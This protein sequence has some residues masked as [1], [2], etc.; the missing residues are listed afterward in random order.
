MRKGN[1]AFLACIIDSR[2]S[3][4]KLDQLPVVSEFADVFPEELSGLPPDRE[5]EF[6]ID[7]VPRTSLITISPAELK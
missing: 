5:V 2:D 3:E 4:S 6:V 1:G 7:L